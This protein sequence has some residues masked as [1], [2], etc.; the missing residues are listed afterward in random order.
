[1][2]VRRRAASLAAGEDWPGLAY[3]VA[4]IG[5]LA[6]SSIHGAL[7]HHGPFESKMVRVLSGMVL[8]VSGWGGVALAT[9]VIVAVTYSAVVEHRG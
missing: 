2:A 3:T 6:L 9:G 4:W 8:L 7:A 1:M 5:S